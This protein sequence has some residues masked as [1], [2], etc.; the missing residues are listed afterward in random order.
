M[1]R[2]IFVIAGLII[3]MTPAFSQQYNEEIDNLLKQINLDSIKITLEELT[4]V[5]QCLIDGELDT[6]YR[7]NYPSNNSATKYLKQRLAIMGYTPTIQ[8]CG[9]E[10]ENVYVELPGLKNP[11]QK[12]IFCA[13]YD[14][15]SV[16]EK[17]PGADDNASGCAVV[18][19]A[20]RLLKNFKPDYT[21]IFAF[22]DAEEIGP[23][24]SN[25]FAKFISDDKQ[26][27][28]AV[29]NMDMIAYNYNNINRSKII[30]RNIAQSFSIWK[31]AKKVNDIYQIGLTLDS[32]ISNFAGGDMIS[33]WDLGYTGIAIEELMLNPC[34]HDSGDLMKFFD[35]DYYQKNAKL[36]FALLLHTA[37]DG[38]TDVKNYNLENN[39]INISITPNPF[40]SSFTL[41]YLD[42]GSNE[43]ASIYVY[44]SYGQIVYS[45]YFNNN[46]Q[47]INLENQ[48]SGIYFVRISRNNNYN[49]R[50]IIKD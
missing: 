30:L 21:I 40:T 42:Y 12:I 26:N 33:F 45:N 7:K 46:L 25:H 47:I 32:L 28:I 4:G 48:A 37:I 16:G 36:S 1:K 3:A 5:R 2:F 34:Y 31:S 22:W 49:F 13:H 20:A 50:Q 29:I 10:I 19:E 9:Q 11:T 27:I 8:D 18:M 6:I 23:L 39:Q 17:A 38:I 41:K 44:N 35:Y 43:M 24:G 14:C 15:E